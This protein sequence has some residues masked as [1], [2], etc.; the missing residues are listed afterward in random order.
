[1]KK[2]KKVVHVS[3]QGSANMLKVPRT[4]SAATCAEAH[5][6]GDGAC[7]FGCLGLGD[8]EAACKKDAIHVIDGVAVVD[9]EKCIGCGLCVRKCPRNIIIQVPVDSRVY[10]G[11]K[12]QGLGKDKSKLCKNACIG[13]TLCAQLCP[14][15]AITIE[16]GLPVIDYEKC[17][18]CGTCVGICPTMLGNSKVIAEAPMPEYD[19]E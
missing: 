4:S 7:A 12:A 13:C 19:A 2:P 9:Y 3:C 10:V 16:N 17:T 8:C 1:M 5:A 6:A 14:S 15:K 18:N 11:C